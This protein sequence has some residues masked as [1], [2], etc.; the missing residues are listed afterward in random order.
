MLF[1][2]WVH[3]QMAQ[4][5][6]LPHA[7]SGHKYSKNVRGEVQQNIIWGQFEDQEPH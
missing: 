5:G 6:W 4:V 3:P 2:D 1:E 7:I